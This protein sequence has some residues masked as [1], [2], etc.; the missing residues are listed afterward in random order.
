MILKGAN[1]P[2]DRKLW[3]ASD[4]LTS[5]MA[6][7]E[8]QTEQAVRE[9][10]VVVINMAH[11][12]EIASETRRIEMAGVVPLRTGSQRIL[13]V[14]PNLGRVL[15]N[16]TGLIGHEVCRMWRLWRDKFDPTIDAYVS[17]SPTTAEKLIRSN[18]EMGQ[19]WYLG[20]MREES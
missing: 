10:R 4:A 5:S 14:N 13:L 1:I 7:L 6:D 17:G 3:F 9:G 12:G 20:L 15:D 2:G 19:P 11:F 8:R 16:T 18:T